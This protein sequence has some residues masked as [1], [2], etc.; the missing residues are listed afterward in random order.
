MTKGLKTVLLLAFFSFAAINANGMRWVSPYAYCAGN[1]VM[2][3]DPDGREIRPDKLS[4]QII[5]NTLSLEEQ[6]FVILNDNGFIDFKTLSLCQSES[7]NFQA[8]RSLVNSPLQIDV[9]SLSSTEYIKEGNRNNEV[10]NPVEI[11]EDFKD[12]EF[13]S[14]SGNTTGETGNLGVTYM[15]TKGGAGKGPV[16]ENSIHININPSLSPTGAAETFSH[17][18]YGHA[19]IYVRTNG[20][21]NMA[22]HYYLAG[23]KEGNRLLVDYTI[24]ARKET[25]KNIMSR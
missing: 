22:V 19:L 1:P 5:L 13:T 18:G 23:C 11:L 21:R 25:V 9:T 15:P 2:Y 20:D 12:T 3:V 16:K 17:E 7:N 24:R 8:L 14:C 10:F 6:P 4:Y